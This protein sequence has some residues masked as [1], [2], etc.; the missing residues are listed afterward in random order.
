MI[1]LS[2]K[3]RV[4]PT[5]HS[6]KVITEEKN[7]RNTITLFWLTLVKRK[8]SI[9]LR[10]TKVK[11]DY[12][13]FTLVIF[14]LWPKIVFFYADHC[15]I[16]ERNEPQ[17]LKIFEQAYIQDQRWTNYHGLNRAQHVFVLPHFVTDCDHLHIIFLKF[18]ICL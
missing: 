2:Y 14:Q 13:V 17:Y 9:Y 15:T 6:T 18:W 11:S 8:D 5:N 3:L 16:I 12:F 10:L 7:T 4:Q 1:K